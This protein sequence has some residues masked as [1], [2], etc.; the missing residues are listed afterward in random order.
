[1]G[2]GICG[3]PAVF[4]TGVLWGEHIGLLP[5]DDR[6]FTIYFVEFPIGRFD[7]CRGIVLPLPPRQD[8]DSDEAGEGAYPLRLHPIP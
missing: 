6:H 4:L 8:F 2:H 5:E 7:S 3:P 1:V